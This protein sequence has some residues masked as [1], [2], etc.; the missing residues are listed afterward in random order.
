M[1]TGVRGFTLLDLTIALTA[2]LV[3]FASVGVVAHSI[4]DAV[5]FEMVQM[6]VQ[7]VGESVTS[8]IGRELPRARILDFQG[9]KAE[10]LS[11]TY[12]I[13]VDVG[14]DDN[15]NRALDAGEDTNGNDALDLSDGDFTAPDG[16]IQW[17]AVENE[18]PRLDTPGSPHQIN[19]RFVSEEDIDEALLM[20]DINGDGDLLD[21]F[22]RG[23]LRYTT[24][25]G[26]TADYG[27]AA[28]F[29]VEKDP[30][31]DLNSDGIPDPLFLIEGEPF[32]DSDRNGVYSPDE[33]FTDRNGS[34]TWDGRIRLNL[35]IWKEFD[36]VRF[37]LRNF[38]RTWELS[39][40]GE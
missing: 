10:T 19:L 29:A 7:E 28:I 13:P 8:A 12:V 2:M 32:T 22:Q 16:S 1:S 34:G 21:V 36:G 9:M 18:G 35:W 15:G 3:I 5:G 17:G 25:G 30:A 39:H 24:T 6:E 4:T 11:L 31:A 40:V 20:F 27:R 23:N 38:S 33:T 37:V 26:L 14:E